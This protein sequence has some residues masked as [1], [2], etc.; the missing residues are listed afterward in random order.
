MKEA[1]SNVLFPPEC[2]FLE[3][4]RENIVHDLNMKDTIIRVVGLERKEKAEPK[5]VFAMREPEDGDIPESLVNVPRISALIERIGGGVAIY[6]DAFVL[7][8]MA[9]QK[10]VSLAKGLATAIALF[11]GTEESFTVSI[12]SYGIKAVENPSETQF[13]VSAVSRWMDDDESYRF[14]RNNSDPYLKWFFEKQDFRDMGRNIIS[15][16]CNTIEDCAKEQG[17]RGNYELSVMP[18]GKL[19][20][21]AFGAISEC[22]WFETKIVGR[23]NSEKQIHFGSGERVELRFELVEVNENNGIVGHLI[24]FILMLETGCQKDINTWLYKGEIAKKMIGFLD[25]WRMAEGYKAYEFKVTEERS[26]F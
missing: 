17:D 9:V 6:V 20:K 13:I 7:D 15:T 5:L 25:I 21:E 19:M 10:Y 22:V 1:L 26:I 16:I 11:R 3:K 24:D 4:V 12:L 8:E 2:V 18:Y 14:W 23:L